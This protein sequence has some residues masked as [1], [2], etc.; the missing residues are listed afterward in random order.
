MTTRDHGL[1]VVSDP[2]SDRPLLEI[3]TLQCVHCGGHFEAKPGSGKIRGFCTNCNG[4]VCGPKCAEC[5]PMEKMLE[6]IEG[7]K[8]PDQVS[9]GGNLWLPSD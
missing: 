2:G 9:V 4:F 3:K 7:T 6:I 8:R 5:V 1:V